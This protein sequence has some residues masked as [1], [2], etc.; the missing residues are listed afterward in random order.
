MK[1]AL[2]KKCCL[3]IYIYIYRFTCMY[4]CVCF[5]NSLHRLDMYKFH[6]SEITFRIWRCYPN[7][8]TFFNVKTSFL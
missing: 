1:F 3:Y 6:F 8:E 5:G 4:V 7:S 2:T